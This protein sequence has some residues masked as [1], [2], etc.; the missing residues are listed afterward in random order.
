MPLACLTDF[1]R[2]EYEDNEKKLT[3]LLML[4]AKNSRQ[5]WKS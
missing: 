5:S 1:A 2:K 3:R 4:A